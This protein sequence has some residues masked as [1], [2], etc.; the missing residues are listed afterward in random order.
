MSLVPLGFLC[1]LVL[2]ETSWINGRGFN[3]VVGC[4]RG[5]VS[6]SRCRCTFTG[7]HLR[8]V[9]DANDDAD[10]AGHHSTTTRATYCQPGISLTGPNNFFINWR[11]VVGCYFSHSESTQDSIY[12]Y[13]LMYCW[14]KRFCSVYFSVGIDLKN[15][16]VRCRNVWNFAQ[17]LKF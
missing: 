8:V 12:I 17:E 10:N 1:L 7:S 6:G 14:T 16:G 11:T 4:W 9:T 5:Y 3:R 2:K 13:T 15:W